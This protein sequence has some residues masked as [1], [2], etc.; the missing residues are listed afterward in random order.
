MTR[1]SSTNTHYM[2]DDQG[3]LVSQRVGAAG[4]P[5]YYLYD[6]L[7]SV[8]AIVNA[9]AGIDQ[10]YTYDAWGNIT[11]SGGSVD[12]PFKYVGGYQDSQT[13]LTKFGTRYYEAATGRWTQLDPS[14]SDPG[15]QYAGCNPTN[16]ID[17]NGYRH[18]GYRPCPSWLN[19][20]AKLFSVG[21]P[22]RGVYYQFRG[23][24]RKVL[25][26]AA[27]SVGAAARPAGLLAKVIPGAAVAGSVVDGICAVYQAEYN[28]QGWVN[29]R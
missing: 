27:G 23:N 13:G 15:Y 28:D 21:G 8:T 2:R 29:Q 3:T 5:R 14:G 10:T 22:I 11:S 1:T 7:G 9:T 25:E 26:E 20:G 16:N 4:A 18:S 6:G 19:T 12:N 17:P 24:S